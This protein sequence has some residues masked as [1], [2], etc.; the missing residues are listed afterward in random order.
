[1]ADIGTTVVRDKPEREGRGGGPPPA[2]PVATGDGGFIRWYKQEQG[3][4]TRGGTFVGLFALILWGGLFLMQRLEIYAGD[5]WWQL[6]ITRGIPLAV[7]VAAWFGAFWVAYSHPKSGDFLIA[8]EGE[9]K[10][11]SWSS[12]REVIGSTRVVIV[13]TLLMA[14]LLFVVDFS[15]QTLF[16]WAGVLKV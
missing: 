5:A 14:I 12:R 8:T 11:V 3:K 9:M 13:M 16:T 15:F 1:M 2:R 7:T 6:L 10:K 4:W